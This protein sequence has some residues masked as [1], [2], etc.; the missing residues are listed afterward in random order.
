MT[1]RLL[2]A[3]AA[4]L[5]ASLALPAGA[6]IRA[7]ELGSVSQV[8]DGTKLTITYS[9]PKVRGR[10]PLWGTRAVQWGE[11]WTPGANWATTL[12][13]SKPITLGGSP[14]PAGKYSVWMVVRKSGDWTFVL[15]P[16][17][18]LFHMA[19][20]DSTADQIRIPVRATE[21]PFTEVLTW[22]FPDF[23]AN[24]G[25]LAMNWEKVRI[26]LDY[27][28]A[29]S[30][31]VELPEAEARPYVGRWTFTS[32][33]GDDKGKVYEF[34][35]TYEQRTLKAEWIPADPYM[36]R[37]ALIRVGA[38]AFTAGLYDKQGRIYEVL[39]PDMIVTF[40]RT[41]GAPASF[42]IRDEKDEL[43]GTATRKP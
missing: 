12:E 23:R 15:D 21:A 1:P 39:R 36:G 5:L 30:L 28:V 40:A 19:H 43:W 6:Q 3:A 14:V 24:G 38:D 7:S 35:V 41:A 32:A 25:T 27:T 18:R 22:S 16:R 42:E 10:S 29:P 2:A 26:A 37:F 11:V 20:P 34:D 33:S 9:R 31:A 17:A 4:S 13:A 8:V